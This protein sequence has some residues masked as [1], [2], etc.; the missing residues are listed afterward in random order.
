MVFLRTMVPLLI[1]HS[2]HIPHSFAITKQVTTNDTATK[3][4]RNPDSGIIIYN[5]PKTESAVYRLL[6]CEVAKQIIITQFT[7]TKCFLPEIGRWCDYFDITGL[8]DVYRHMSAAEACPKKRSAP[9][10]AG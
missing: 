3:T 10:L 5:Q 7:K 8:D 6:I 4:K 1:G 2:V 9:L